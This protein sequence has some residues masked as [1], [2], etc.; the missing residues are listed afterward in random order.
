MKRFLAYA[1]DLEPGE[2]AIWEQA[3]FDIMAAYAAAT[4]DEDD[5][6]ID[7]ALLNEPFYLL[8]SIS[9]RMFMAP[10]QTAGDAPPD[11]QRRYEMRFYGTGSQGWW[12]GTKAERPCPMIGGSFSPRR[13]WRLSRKAFITICSAMYFAK[14]RN[15]AGICPR[16]CDVCRR[17]SDLADEPVRIVGDDAIDIQVFDMFPLP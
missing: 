10:V 14:R 4:G 16:R 17:R 6:P 12:I 5:L 15:G 7:L 9:P 8:E 13:M 3:G 2:R 1:Q 11:W